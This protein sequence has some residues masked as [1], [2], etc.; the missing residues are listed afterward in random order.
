MTKIKIDYNF[1][2]VGKPI[3]LRVRL[4]NKTV[5]MAGKPIY[6]L[7]FSWK[8]LKTKQQTR[9]YLIWLSSH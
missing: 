4:T 6:C 2:R 1:F 3:F 8:E 9:Q 5:D 7:E